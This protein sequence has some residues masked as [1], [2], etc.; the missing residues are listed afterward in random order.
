M[1]NRT[2]TRREF[3]GKVITVSAAAAAAGLAAPA[4]LGA[5]KP[6]LVVVG[7]GAGGGTVARYVAKGSE[8]VDVTLINDSPSYSTCF[9]SNLYLGGFQS[10]ESITHNYDSL[11]ADY[12]IKVVIDRADGLDGDSRTV[13]LAGGDK[14]TYDKAVVAPGID[15]KYEAIEG[16]SPEASEKMPHAWQAGAQTKNLKRQ[17]LDMEDGGT[18]V[19]CPPPNPFRCPPGPYE[20]ISMVAHYFKSY[21]PRSKIVVVDAKNKFSKQKLFEDGWARH[22]PD[23]VEWLPL[24][25]TGGVKAVD[26]ATN[27]IMTED[28][29]FEA[30]VAN[31]VPPQKAGQIAQDAGLADDSGWCPIDP[32]T[33]ASRLAPDVHLVG[34]AIIPGDMPKSAFSANSQA[35]VCAQAVLAELAGKQAFK[36]R[37]RNTCWSLITTDDSVK[38]GANYEATEEKI[39]KIEGFVSQPDESDEV[40]AQTA[41]EARG[42]YDAITAD[43][44]G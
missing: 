11:A 17:L 8:D 15:F 41:A 23:M 27:T 33:L 3:G 44:F 19:I 40:R 2:M 30:S 38:V 18:F 43:I 21:K 36:P 32:A 20:R 24:D 37:F 25:I 34:D 26:P 39:A 22:F 4:V 10:F 31:V 28:E 13:T 16:Y 1:T 29:T 12:G 35:K 7:G 5:A 6:R 14:L 9:F 42:W